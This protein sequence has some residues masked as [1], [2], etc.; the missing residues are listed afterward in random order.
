MESGDSEYISITSENIPNMETLE[1]NA[2][3]YIYGYFDDI[4][5]SVDL[6]R[7]DLIQRIHNYSDKIIKSIENTQ[8]EC[9]KTSKKVNQLTVEVEKSKRN[10]K[11]LIKSF[12]TNEKI[13]ESIEILIEANKKVLKEYNDAL[14]GFNKYSFDFNE[15]EIKDIFGYFI[16]TEKVSGKL[17][18]LV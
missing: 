10:L 14:L 6:R 2:E 12:N 16:K 17:F 4:K 5:R 11:D 9:L 7:E 3:L 8:A 18:I 15:I 13:T 1:K